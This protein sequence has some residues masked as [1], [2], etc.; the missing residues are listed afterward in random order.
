VIASFK[1]DEAQKIYNTGR[2]K[3]YGNLARVA[4]R[5]LG[6]IDFAETLEDLRDPPGN[7]LEALKG[8]RKGQYS[9]RINDRYRVC[10][11]WLN[12]KAWDVEIADYH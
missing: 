10:F 5:R 12:N 3:R 6:A 1:D 4:A 9:I 2:S 8:D 7:R 11:R